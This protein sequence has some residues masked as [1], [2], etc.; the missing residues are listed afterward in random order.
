MRINQ[1]IVFP[2]FSRD[3]NYGRIAG[4]VSEYDA[5]TAYV[6]SF[7]E[8]LDNLGVRPWDYRPDEPIYPNTLIIHCSIGWIEPKDKPTKHNY[9]TISYG[10]TQSRSLADIFAEN[11]TGW[12]HCYINHGHTTK[13]PKRGDNRKFMTA[14][15]TLS[16]SI[17]PFLANG[18][19]IED[20]IRHAPMLG[21]MLAIAVTDFMNIRGELPKLVSHYKT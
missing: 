9:S 12:G 20:Y 8:N 6:E 21:K 16:V 14:A 1:V 10:T 19:D 18:P 5:V 11:T 17:S 7:K 15:D 3:K 13:D 2:E 4:S